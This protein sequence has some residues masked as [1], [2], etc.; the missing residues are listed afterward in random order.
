VV[1]RVWGGSCFGLPGP[2]ECRGILDDRSC[3]AR[4]RERYL[5]GSR[6][7]AASSYQTCSMDMDLTL[8][9]RAQVHRDAHSLI[10]ETIAQYTAS[11]PWASRCA[12]G[13]VSDLYRR[14]RRGRRVDG[15]AALASTP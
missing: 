5:M 9:S 8:R 11:V 13:S 7:I 3:S 10:G 14:C 1:P 15:F 12:A 4:R 6:G 2:D